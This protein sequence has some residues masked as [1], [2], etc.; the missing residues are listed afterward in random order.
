MARSPMSRPACSIRRE[1]DHY[2]FDGGACC[3]AADEVRADSRRLLRVESF[4][5]LRLH[6]TLPPN[7][8]VCSSRSVASPDPQKGLTAARK[9]IES[10]QMEPVHNQSSLNCPVSKRTFPISHGCE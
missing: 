1:P 2:F 7:S 8:L 6:F 5:H 9:R 3:Q 4:Y 10:L